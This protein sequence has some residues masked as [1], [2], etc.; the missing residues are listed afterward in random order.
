MNY[1]GLVYYM[2]KVMVTQWSRGNRFFPTPQRDDV[3]K[4]CSDIINIVNENKKSEKE[5]E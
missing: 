5:Y 3:V 4:V 2:N 1:K